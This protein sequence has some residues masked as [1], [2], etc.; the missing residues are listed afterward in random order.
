MEIKIWNI[1]DIHN[2]N[3]RCMSKSKEG[4]KQRN[5]KNTDIQRV[6]PLNRAYATT[7]SPI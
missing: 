7:V 4:E 5:R 6:I 1:H 3:K 2:R